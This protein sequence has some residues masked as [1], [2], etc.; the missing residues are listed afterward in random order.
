MV[1][2]KRKSRL[3]GHRFDERIKKKRK[4]IRDTL[5]RRYKVTSIAQQTERV[6]ELTKDIERLVMKRER[7]KIKEQEGFKRR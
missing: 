1:Q 5:D 6:L 7:H 4:K 3:D 2:G